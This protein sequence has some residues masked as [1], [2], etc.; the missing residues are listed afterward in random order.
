MI[1]NATVLF[2][3]NFKVLKMPTGKFTQE[4][5]AAQL[6]AGEVDPRSVPER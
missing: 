1:I 2:P 5:L 6:L 3:V 4:G